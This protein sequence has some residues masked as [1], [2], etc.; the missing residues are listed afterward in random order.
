MLLV[1]AGDAA[2]TYVGLTIGY[3]L[4]VKSPLRHLGNSPSSISFE[5]YQPLIWLGVLI[6]LAS[7]IYLR[8]YNT[9]LLMRPHRSVS[10]MMKGCFWWLF[11]FLGFS[12]TFSL[13]PAISRLF[14]VISTLTTFLS[15]TIW[16]FAMFQVISTSAWRSRLVQRVIIIGW[17]DE[18][19]KLVDSI[20]HDANHPYEITGLVLDAGDEI[21]HPRDFMGDR[22]LG[23]TDDLE[24]IIKNQNCDIL[25]V[26]NPE[27]P[28]SRLLDLIELS[29]RLYVQLKVIPS[30]F[31]VFVSSLRMQSISGVPILGIEELPVKHFANRAVKRILDIMGA[32]VGLLLSSPIM[33]VL[34]LIIRKESPGP[35]VYRQTRTGLRGAAFTIYKLR[36]MK[37]DAETSGA[38]WAVKDDDRR[39]Q[40]GTFMRA[41]NLDELPQFWNVLKGDMSLVGPRPERPELIQQF[42]REIAHYNP[43]HEVRPG[44]TGWA[45]VN[46]LRGNTSLVDRIKYDLYYIENWS[47]WFDIQIMALTF[48][49]T[50]N[51]Y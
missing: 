48:R 43:R 31:Q 42:E 38:Q 13:E 37:L 8:A 51:A 28:R 27:I 32:S 29:E 15:L 11:I 30:F 16:R 3:W 33:L 40:I 6:L 9:R 44:M 25:V 14:V 39:L 22:L 10:L 20:D 45:Q 34:T 1:F 12:L 4:R 36:S 19:R 41:W 47:I 24:N 5:R 18:A 35:V 23:S 21:A 46:G 26:A 17:T 49:R 50:E 7:F 2:T